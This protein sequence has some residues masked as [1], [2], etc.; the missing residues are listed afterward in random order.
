MISGGRPDSVGGV[1]AELFRDHHRPARF[2][3]GGVVAEIFRGHHRPARFGGGGVV[4]R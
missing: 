3:G 2:G 4:F 1:V